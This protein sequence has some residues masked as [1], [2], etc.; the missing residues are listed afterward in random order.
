[1]FSGKILEHVTVS[2]LDFIPRTITI[3]DFYESDHQIKQVHEHQWTN[4]SMI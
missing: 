2:D 3:L 1:M 4:Q